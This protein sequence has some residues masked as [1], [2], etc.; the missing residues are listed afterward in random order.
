[1]QEGLSFFN[2]FLLVFAAIGLVVACFTIYNTFQIVVTQRSREMALLRAVGAIA[3]PGARRPSCSRPFVVGVVASVVG[4]VAGVFV[5]G[6]LKAMMERFGIDIPAGGTVLLARTAVVALVVGTV[7]TVVSAVFPSLRASRIPPLAA[8]RDVVAGGIAAA[9]PPPRSTAP[10]SRSLGVGAFVGR[11]RRVGHRSGSVSA[12]CR[13]S[14]ACS[15]SDRSSP[16]QWSGLLGAPL[17]ALS[18]ITGELAREN[19]MR[20]PKRTARTGGALMVGVAL[21]AA[22]TVI[23]GVAQGLDPRRLRASSSPAT[24]S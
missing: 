19:A 18:G 6:L 12:R 14:S 11:A 21:V 20:N 9:R 23:A 22:I 5:A 15:C 1:M 3:A 8:L 4:L 17:P 10:H 24:T 2:T 13:S 16:A 7:V